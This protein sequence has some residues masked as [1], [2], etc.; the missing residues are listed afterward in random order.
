VVFNDPAPAARLTTALRRGRGDANVMPADPTTGSEDF[1]VSGRVA[2]VPSIQL[3]IGTIESAEFARA[4]EAGPT[5]RPP[6]APG[7]RR[8]PSR[9]WSV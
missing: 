9:L 5:A 8:S 3:W 6:S 1:G 7:S 4:K 2:G